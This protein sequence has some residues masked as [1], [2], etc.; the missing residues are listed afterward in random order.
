[1]A[2]E[3]KEATSV[4]TNGAEFKNRRRRLRRLARLALYE[5]T[6]E[7]RK[8]ELTTDMLQK[9]KQQLRQ[10]AA[11]ISILRQR[12]KKL[13][14]STAQD[15]RDFLA[16]PDQVES[17][18]CDL[19]E[20]L[21]TVSRNGHDQEASMTGRSGGNLVDEPMAPMAEESEESVHMTVN[22]DPEV[23]GEVEQ[24]G[25]SDMVKVFIDY[26]LESRSSPTDSVQCDLSLEDDTISEEA[27]AKLYKPFK[28]TKHR[29]S[30][31]NSKYKRFEQQMHQRRALSSIGK[32]EC[33]YG[34]CSSVHSTFESFGRHLRRQKNRTCGPDETHLAGMAAEG[35]MD[36]DFCSDQHDPAYK[37]AKTEGYKRAQDFVDRPKLKELEQP[38]SAKSRT[39][40][41]L[42]DVVLGPAS[43]LNV[44]WES[45][46]VVF[47]SSA[48]PSSGWAN[49]SRIELS[50]LFAQRMK[51]QEQKKFY[52]GVVYSEQEPRSNNL[53]Q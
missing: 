20:E 41:I 47:G 31:V 11:L 22:A 1:M 26:M 48:I 13:A 44:L 28:L 5:E 50:E 30:N 8:H 25:Y 4:A 37:R 16:E 9:R 3:E 24:M 19:D 46:D 10:P 18:L 36:T 14:H 42:N 32:Y 29:N 27:K 12:A 51:D 49:D 52:T 7:L 40:D 21:G 34:D 43:A 39:G 45:S 17:D 35:W 53:F 2:E 33:P 15:V 38:R 23:Y 6:E